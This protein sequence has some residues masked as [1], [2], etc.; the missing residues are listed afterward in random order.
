[1]LSSLNTIKKRRKHM[2]WLDYDGLLY[3]WQKIKAKSKSLK[4]VLKSGAK[5]SKQIKENITA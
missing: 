1:M 5:L 4:L 3:F 2:A